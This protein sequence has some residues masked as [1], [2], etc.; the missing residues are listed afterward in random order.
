[1]LGATVATLL[2][3]SAQAQ[4]I[5]AVMHAD[6]K[7]ID[8]IWTSAY[9]VRN[10]GYMVYD[11][12]L[13]MDEKLAVQ[14]QMLEGWKISDDKLT[15][16]FTLRDGLKFH[17]GAPVT[18]ADCIA[19]LQRWAPKDAMGQKLFSMVK[20]LTPVDDKSFVM[21]LTEPYGL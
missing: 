8:P 13:A 6:I 10:Y 16:T 18:S 3:V 17:D 5:R 20:E 2:S 12:L 19:S 14:P 7:I 4:T 21:V 9:N 11:T 15:Y 1:A